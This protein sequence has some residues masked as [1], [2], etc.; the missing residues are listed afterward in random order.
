MGVFI[1]ISEYSMCAIAVSKVKFIEILKWQVKAY[2]YTFFYRS[3]SFY[4][5]TSCFVFLKYTV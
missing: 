4:I 2:S 3:V 1:V 5:Y